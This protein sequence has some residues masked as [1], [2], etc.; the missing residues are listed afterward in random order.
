MCNWFYWIVIIRYNFTR[1]DAFIGFQK[2]TPAAVIFQA[3]TLLK[4]A[5]S[6]AKRNPDST[7]GKWKTV[8]EQS[9]LPFMKWGVQQEDSPELWNSAVSSW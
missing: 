6:A 2:D 7:E 4:D 5:C 3:T 1:A 9:Q 8:L